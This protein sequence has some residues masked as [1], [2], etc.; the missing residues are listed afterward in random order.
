MVMAWLMWVLLGL[1][2]LAIVLA[3]TGALPRFRGAGRGRAPRRVANSA[4]RKSVV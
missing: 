2:V 3:T 1:G 4:D